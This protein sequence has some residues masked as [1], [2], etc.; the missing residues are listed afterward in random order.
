[1][2][3]SATLDSNVRG[4]TEGTQHVGLTMVMVILA[5]GEPARNALPNSTGKKSRGTQRMDTTSPLVSSESDYPKG[6]MVT[7]ACGNC[8]GRIATGFEGHSFSVKAGKVVTT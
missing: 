2:S 1:M 4:H 3:C 7:E 5:I 6:Q 8:G